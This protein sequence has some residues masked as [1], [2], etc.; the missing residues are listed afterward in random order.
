MR[1]EGSSTAESEA[2]TEAEYQERFQQMVG[3]HPRD[4]LDA[5][6]GDK[7]SPLRKPGLGADLRPD[8]RQP[9]LPPP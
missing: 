3:E 9:L 6:C 4:F 7:A 2:D 8:L 5:G 1:E